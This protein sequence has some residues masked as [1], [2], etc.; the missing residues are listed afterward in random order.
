M[1]EWLAIQGLRGGP[2]SELKSF[3]DNNIKNKLKAIGLLKSDLEKYI[4]LRHLYRSPSAFHASNTLRKE[5][6]DE[7]RKFI[8]KEEIN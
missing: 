7:G 5:V 1:A 8:E 4:A 6:S 3:C 2:E